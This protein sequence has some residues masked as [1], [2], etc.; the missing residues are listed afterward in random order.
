M[1]RFLTWLGLAVLVAVIVPSGVTLVVIGIAGEQP[2][3]DHHVVVPPA[4]GVGVVANDVEVRVVASADSAVHIDTTGTSSLFDPSVRSVDGDRAAT[5]TVEPDVPGVPSTPAA[6]RPSSVVTVDG[7]LRCDLA[8]TVATPRGVPVHV[9]G[10][11]TGITA[12]GVDAPLRLQSG[13]GP[14]TTHDFSGPTLIADSG[15]GTISLGLRRPAT[16][17]VSTGRGDVTVTAPVS[18]RYALDPRTGSGTVT[19]TLPDDPTS[20]TRISVNTGRGN[21]TLTG[22]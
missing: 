11:P 22:S 5:E 3:E 21:I 13:R 14:I 4:T 9:S 10:L 7:C 19:A 2:Y 12:T 1:T 6:E 16:T 17:A 8:V 20:P 15:R 18:G